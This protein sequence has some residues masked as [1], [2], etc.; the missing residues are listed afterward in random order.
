MTE[1]L[2]VALALL[3]GAAMLSMVPDE[4]MA[5]CEQAKPRAPSA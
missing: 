2:L 4:P 5:V 3:A 1:R